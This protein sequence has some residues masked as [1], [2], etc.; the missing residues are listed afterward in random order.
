[1]SAVRDK[2]LQL[3]RL[4]HELL[5]QIRERGRV[6]TEREVLIREL[7]ARFVSVVT[8]D[9]RASGPMLARAVVAAIAGAGREPLDAGVAATTSVLAEHLDV[10]IRMIEEVVADQAAVYLAQSDDG[11]R[12]L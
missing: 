12:F 8:R 9:G 2:N 5:G 3:E 7:K 4:N 10:R 6:E 1:M 11:V